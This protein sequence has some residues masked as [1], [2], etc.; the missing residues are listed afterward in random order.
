MGPF[1]GPTIAILI[2]LAILLF[3]AKKLPDLARSLGRSA[4]ILKAESKGLVDDDNNESEDNADTRA[5][6]HQ[7]Q[8]P[9]QNAPGQPQQGYQQQGYPQPQQPQ[10]QGYPQLPPGQRIVDE[11]G[12][13]THRTYGN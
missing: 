3:G 4:R 5:Q 9:Q 13:T 12:E 6:T 1:N 11:S 7:Q 8:A 10:Q 2:V